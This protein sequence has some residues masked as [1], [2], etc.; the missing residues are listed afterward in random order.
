MRCARG[1]LWPSRQD[2]VPPLVLAAYDALVAVATEET[3]LELQRQR[4][5]EA[6]EAVAKA[7]QA[8]KDKRAQRDALAEKD[9]RARGRP[10]RSFFL[11][12]ESDARSEVGQKHYDC[13]TRFARSTLN[14]DDQLLNKSQ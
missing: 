1:N 4:M 12:Y 6:E 3:R 10:A 14:H 7:K 2:A 9:R 5:V 11:L 8:E 13:G